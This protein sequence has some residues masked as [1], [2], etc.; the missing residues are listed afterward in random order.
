LV[1]QAR[2]TKRKLDGESWIAKAD[3]QALIA[4]ESWI[5]KAA[6]VGTRDREIQTS[7]VQIVNYQSFGAHLRNVRAH[8]VEVCHIADEIAASEAFGAARFAEGS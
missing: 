2:H 3:R 4:S 5:A 7:K 1:A 6:T 8:D